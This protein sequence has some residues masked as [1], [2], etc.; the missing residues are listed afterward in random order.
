VPR[1]IRDRRTGLTARKTCQCYPVGERVRALKSHPVKGWPPGRQPNRRAIPE[2]GCPKQRQGENAGRGIELR[3]MYSCGRRISPGDRTQ[4]RL[5]PVT[6]RQQSCSRQGERRG[7]HRG[8]RAG[9]AF[10]CVE[11]EAGHDLWA[12]ERQARQRAHHLC[13]RNS[14]G[15]RGGQQRV[16]RLSGAPLGSPALRRVLTNR[17][18]ENFTYGSVGGAGA[19]PAPTRQ[20]TAAAPGN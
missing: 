15:L 2:R 13:Q 3:K 11:G 12:R 8:L 4:S 16:M 18:R 6:G 5:C 10:N 1:Q 7:H 14:H 9:H 20:P 19:I 17:M